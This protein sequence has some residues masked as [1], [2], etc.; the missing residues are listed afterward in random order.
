MILLSKDT[1]AESFLKLGFRDLQEAR[2]FQRLGK[3]SNVT[4][5][6]MKIRHYIDAIK[7]CR[8]GKRYA[9]LAL[10]E[11]KT[12]IADKSD[13]KKQTIEDA[14]NKPPRDEIADF[15]RVKNTLRNMIDRKLLVDS[16]DIFTHHHDNFGYMQREDLLKKYNGNLSE[17]I[18][19]LEEKQQPT[20]DTGK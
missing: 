19:E 6:S 17:T 15:D 1:R 13:F 12:P 2:R 11:S 9:F 7:H 5:H 8:Q 18:A 14:L 16:Y 10:I 3:N 4:L 20:D